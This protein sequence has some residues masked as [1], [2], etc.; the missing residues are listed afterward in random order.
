MGDDR[1]LNMKAYF[2]TQL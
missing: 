2:V 1:R